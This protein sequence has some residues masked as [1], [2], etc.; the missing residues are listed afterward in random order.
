MKYLLLTMIRFYRRCL[1]PLKKPCCRFYPTCSRYAL[2]AVRVW[3]PVTGVGLAA[4]RLLR[5]QPFS[6]GGYDP[7]P[8]RH[9]ADAASPSIR[10]AWNL[11]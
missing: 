5:C 3:G 2:D 6:R 1:S 4:W 9:T 7:V 10:K 8:E 11:Q